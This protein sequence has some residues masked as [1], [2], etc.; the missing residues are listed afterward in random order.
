[1]STMGAEF[2]NAM[3][4]SITSVQG[5]TKGSKGIFASRITA[6]QNCG[7]SFVAVTDSDGK[8]WNLVG[9][10]LMENPQSH[11]TRITR[12]SPIDCSEVAML[13]TFSWRSKHIKTPQST[14][15]QCPPGGQAKVSFTHHVERHMHPQA[16]AAFHVY[17]CLPGIASPW[18]LLGI[19]HL[20]FLKSTVHNM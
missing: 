4:V 15:S 3:T 7:A 1:M 13:H 8:R 6:I 16:Y 14:H 11:M 2:H 12:M 20:A 5:Y 17:I 18:R 19:L 9:K 10:M